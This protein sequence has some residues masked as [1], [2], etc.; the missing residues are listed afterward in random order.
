M[1]LAAMGTMMMAVYSNSSAIPT[2]RIETAFE[3]AHCKTAK[4]KTPNASSIGTS[5]HD[6]RKAFGFVKTNTPPASRAE[7]AERINT[8]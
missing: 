3:Y 1:I 2:G 6:K 4:P 5:R 8:N 7:T